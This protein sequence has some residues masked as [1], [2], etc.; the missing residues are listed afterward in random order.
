MNMID[1]AAVVAAWMGLLALL[2]A[3]GGLGL[4]LVSWTSYRADG[5]KLGF[6]AFLRGI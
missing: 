2:G 6:W 4:V 5:G 3:V 1:A